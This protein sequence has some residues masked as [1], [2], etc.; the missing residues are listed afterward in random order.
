MSGSGTL[1][2]TIPNIEN[3]DKGDYYCVATNMWDRSIESN[4]VTLKVYGMLVYV[5]FC[6][7]SIIYGPDWT[8]GPI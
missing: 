3:S 8:N 1:N 4:S 6:W 5:Q 7:L 2:L